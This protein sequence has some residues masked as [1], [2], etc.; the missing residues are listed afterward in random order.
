[1]EEQP[2]TQLD[3]IWPAVQAVSQPPQWKG[4][5]AVLTHERPHWV[6]TVGQAARHA[7]SPQNW[8]ASQAVLQVPQ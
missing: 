1:M 3:R 7:P 6:S 4:L 8:V 2:Q 5:T